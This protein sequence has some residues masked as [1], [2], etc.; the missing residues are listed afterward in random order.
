MHAKQRTPRTS[1]GPA[2]LPASLLLPP[3]RRFVMVLKQT[4]ILAPRFCLSTPK[5]SRLSRR[6]II[7]SNSKRSC[8]KMVH[9]RRSAPGTTFRQLDFKIFF[10]R[11]RVES[12]PSTPELIAEDQEILAERHDLFLRHVDSLERHYN[13]M[14]S[15]LEDHAQW[16]EIFEDIF[17]SESEDEE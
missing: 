3:H 6:T 5:A 17:G 14:S 4:S 8:K 16:M 15:A 13:S 2:F 11:P 9:K 1:R 10:I 7:P 12:R